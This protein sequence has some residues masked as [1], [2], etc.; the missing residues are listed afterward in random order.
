MTKFTAKT[1]N[2]PD[3]LTGISDH[4]IEN[5]LALY[6]EY[7]DNCNDILEEIRHTKDDKENHEEEGEIVDYLKKFSFNF[8]GM[9]NHEAY[10]AML[11][12]GPI[13]LPKDSDFEKAIIEEWGSFDEWLEEIKT[14]AELGGV[15]WAM[16]FLDAHSNCLFN[17]WVDDQHIGQLQ[18]SCPLV[19]IDMYEHAYLLD[20]DSSDKSQ[21]IRNFVSNIN[22]EE[23]SSRYDEEHEEGE[24]EDEVA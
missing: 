15:G 2:L 17:A 11:E 22:W 8:N 16:L 18:Y 14:I 1:F 12:G 13:P 20:Y 7:V 5:H 9:R 3:T 6:E 10:F 24:G 19:A 23:V 4:T 21:Y